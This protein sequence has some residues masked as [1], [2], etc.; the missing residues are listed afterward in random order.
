MKVIKVKNFDLFDVMKDEESIEGKIE[1]EINVK[2]N[3]TYSR[4]ILAWLGTFYVK[5]L[6]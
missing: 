4:Y 5:Q 6:Q 1:L 3:Q 2:Q